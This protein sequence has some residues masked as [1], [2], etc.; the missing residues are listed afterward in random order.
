M[1]HALRAQVARIAQDGVDPAEL[2]RVKTQWM[3]SNIYERDSVMNQAQQLGSY[4]V[5]G[6]PLDAEDRL[7]AQ[8]RTI[9][10]QQVQDVAARYFGDDAL[11]VATLRPQPLDGKPPR[12]APAP[13]AR[14]H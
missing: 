8:L 5:L 1:E 2:E 13:G 14:L 3:A 10:P 12:P 4:W 11:T 6:M 7:L 9:T